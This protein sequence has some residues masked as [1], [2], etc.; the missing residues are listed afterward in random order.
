MFDDRPGRCYTSVVGKSRRDRIIEL[1]RQIAEHREQ[2]LKEEAEFDALLAESGANGSTP[3][4][5][6]LGDRL[7]RVL[8]ESPDRAFQAPQLM[9]EAGIPTG[10]LPTVRTTLARL[11]ANKLVERGAEKGTYR[12]ATHDASD[13]SAGETVQ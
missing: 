2:L 8:R 7:L 12:V 5:N 1:G 4:P 10:Q 13:D 11:V 6:S 9:D 3:G